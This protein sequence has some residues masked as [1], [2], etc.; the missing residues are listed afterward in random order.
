MHLEK[1]KNQ[2]KL[3]ILI[4]LKTRKDYIL[5]LDN[6][7]DKEITDTE[8]SELINIIKFCPYQDICILTLKVLAR[9]KDYQLVNFYLEIINSSRYS[10]EVKREAIS[11]IGRLRSKDITMSKLSKFINDRNPEITLQVIRALLVF[12]N[13]CDVKEKLKN[14]YFNTSN[15]IIKRVLDVEFNFTN[16]LH[17]TKL[18]HTSINEKYKNKVFHGDAL[19]ILK[20]MDDKSIHLTFTSPPYYNAR[21]YSIYPSYDA[22]LSILEEI[23]KEVNRITKDGRFLVVNTSPIIV[24]RAGRKYSSIRYPIPFDLHTRLIN[25]NWDFIDDIVWQKP[26]YSVK[27]RI[28]GFYQYRKP[29]TYKPNA[30]TEYIMVYRKKAK[31]Y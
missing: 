28:G 12:K 21:D 4:D 16:E 23:F 1:T 19:E 14:L 13:D 8:K 15:E 29:L 20:N 25:N 30:V 6:Y 2:L 24:P 5:I 10:E 11:S 3:D 27:N 31:D 7:K 26:E 18:E 9:T 17:E 22:Y